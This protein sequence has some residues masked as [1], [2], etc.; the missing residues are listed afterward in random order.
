MEHLW[1]VKSCVFSHPAFPGRS[2]LKHQNH[3]N[4]NNLWV[5]SEV[6]TPADKKI[7]AFFSLSPAG[8]YKYTRPCLKAQY[9]KRTGF[10]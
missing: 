10:K 5:L 4:R 1:S 2:P 6:L 8:V 7:S 3:Q 9:K